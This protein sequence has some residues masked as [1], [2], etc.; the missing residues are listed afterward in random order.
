MVRF[1]NVRHTP[2]LAASLVQAAVADAVRQPFISQDPQHGLL[3]G[4]E[5]G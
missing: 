1:V 4:R 5:R 3:A 2:A